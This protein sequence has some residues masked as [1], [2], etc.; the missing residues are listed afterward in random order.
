MDETCDQTC[1]SFIDSVQDYSEWVFRFCHMPR[2]EDD[3]DSKRMKTA[4]CIILASPGPHAFV[5][6]VDVSKIGQIKDT[7]RTYEH[8]LGSDFT[9]YL[10]I[11]IKVDENR[12][13]IAEECI[14]SF[15]NLHNLPKG[16]NRCFV[17][18]NVSNRE[19]QAKDMIRLLVKS[20]SNEGKY[21]INEVFKISENVIKKTE[22]DI[23][24]E[25]V[26]KVKELT[27]DLKKLQS[28]KIS[29]A[30]ATKKVLSTDTLFE[31]VGFEKAIN[32]L[33]NI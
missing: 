2:K 8:V 16:E 33:I 22:E 29:R 11:G 9:D 26:Q 1:Q 19:K 4:K 20:I 24:G 31:N 21:F 15:M 27:R 23:E 17:F 18:D 7:I 6:L 3:N 25:K 12:T 13:I 30:T 32:P 28:V 14:Q 10:V 5:L